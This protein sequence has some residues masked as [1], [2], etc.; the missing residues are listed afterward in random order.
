MGSSKSNHQ[1]PC[2][3]PGTEE[4]SCRVTL[5]DL[6]NQI[7]VYRSIAIET[8]IRQVAFERH[9]Y[10]EIA[11]DGPVL[12]MTQIQPCLVGVKLSLLSYL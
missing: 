6:A 11:F 12:S 3:L 2:P 1:D 7:T 8:R 9:L 5:T 4:Q 10:K